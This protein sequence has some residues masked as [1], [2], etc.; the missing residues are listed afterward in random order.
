LKARSPLR[1]MIATGSRLTG[2]PMI[3]KRS[4][5]HALEARPNC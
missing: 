1:T 2:L 3:R 5:N 4:I